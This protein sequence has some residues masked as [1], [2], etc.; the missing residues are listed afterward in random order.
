MK[1]GFD[2]INAEGLTE[3]EFLA[4]YDAS[5]FQRPSVTAD[6]FAYCPPKS[7]VLL[8]KRKNHP[9][10]GKWA[11]PGGF[12]ENGETV[13]DAARRELFEETGVAAPALKQ[14][15]VFSN[16]NRDPRTRIITVAFIAFVNGEYSIAGDDAAEAAFFKIKCEK[17]EVRGDFEA[18]KISLHSGGE[19]IH[20][21]YRKTTPPAAFP[22]DPAFETLGKA[23]LA[24]D[25]AEI[26][27]AAYDTLGALT[28]PPEILS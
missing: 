12:V 26:I 3:K 6:I 10:I 16:P 20:F 27:A 11:L 5:K 18:G 23:R 24:G 15:R 9:F 21:I 8:V 28:A 17:L 2:P 19:T 25:H 7:S 13:E 14:L 22:A 1:N 4:R